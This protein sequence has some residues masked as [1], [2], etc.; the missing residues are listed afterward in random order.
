[1][2]GFC[3]CG[4]KLKWDGIL[5]GGKVGFALGCD[6]T[7]G[8]GVVMEGATD[9]TELGLDEL[10]VGS[11][12][13]AA[14]GHSDGSTL[15]TVL[16]CELGVAVGNKEILSLGPVLGATDGHSETCAVGCVDGLPLRVTLGYKLWAVVGSNVGCC[17]GCWLGR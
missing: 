2:D 8:F 7:E 6:I 13:G 11:V 10:L 15:C 9:G 16:E 3:V 17:E 5:D 12:L 14:D 4:L 1:V